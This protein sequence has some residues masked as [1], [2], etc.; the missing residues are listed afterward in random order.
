M[1]LLLLSRSFRWPVIALILGVSWLG[2]LVKGFR[3][4]PP[5][6]WF[7]SNRFVAS[8]VFCIKIVAHTVAGVIGDK[9]NDEGRPP[10]LI[11]SGG[12]AGIKS[13]SSVRP[14]GWGNTLLGVKA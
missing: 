6:I 2:L 13:V 9:P 14:R 10:M 4:R 1:E 12:G 8:E 11:S 7:Q 3:N 5:K